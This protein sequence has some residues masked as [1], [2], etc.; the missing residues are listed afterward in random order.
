MGARRWPAN[1]LAAVLL[2]ALPSG[3][4]GEAV[5]RPVPHLPAGDS[6]RGFMEQVERYSFSEK[7]FGN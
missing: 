6:L 3:A 5:D 4:L 7:D 2:G 1:T